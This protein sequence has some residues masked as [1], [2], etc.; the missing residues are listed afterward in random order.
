MV[1]DIENDFDEKT[2]T[3][4]RGLILHKP[5]DISSN[6]WKVNYAKEGGRKTSTR[7]QGYWT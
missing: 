6:V 2:N 5:P 4:L 3:I 1:H 7:A